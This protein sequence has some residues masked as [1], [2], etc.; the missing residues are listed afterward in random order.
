MLLHLLYSLVVCCGH[1]FIEETGMTEKSDAEVRENE[2]AED[3]HERE[4]VVLFGNGGIPKVKRTVSADSS[5]AF[6]KTW[7][8]RGPRSYESGG[9]KTQEEMFHM[10][11]MAEPQ[12]QLYTKLLRVK[13]AGVL[14][15]LRAF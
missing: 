13:V 8:R 4:R 3:A 1:A 7:T 2:R 12:K 15:Q 5:G 6:R 9:L 10:A 11:V 14:Q